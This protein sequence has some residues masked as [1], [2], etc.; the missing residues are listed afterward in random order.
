MHRLNLTIKKYILNA[1]LGILSGGFAYYILGLI[2]FYP[3]DL[4]LFLVFILFLLWALKPTFGVAATL[5]LFLFPIAYNSVTLLFLFIAFIILIAIIDSSSIGP[6]GFFILAAAVICVIQPKLAFLVLLLPVLAGFMGMRRGMIM[7]AVTACWVQAL[8]CLMGRPDVGLLFTP[9]A[10]KPLITLHMWPL[11]SL[12][13]V[14][15][16]NAYANVVS[17]DSRITSAFFLPYLKNPI[18]LIQLALWALCAGVVAFLISRPIVKKVPPY[19]TAVVAGVLVLG[20]GYLVIPALFGLVAPKFSLF[21]LSVLVSA[22]V[23]A[24]VS[25]GLIRVVPLILPAD[26]KAKKPTAGVKK[27]WSD[28]DGMEEVRVF[29]KEA[30]ASQLGAKPSALKQGGQNSPAAGVLLFG[31]PETGM[32]DLARVMAHES[33]ATFLSINRNDVFPKYYDVFVSYSTKD[34]NVAD[35]VVATLEKNNIRCWYA[36]RD[37]KPGSDWGKAVADAIKASKLFLLIFS[38][39]SDRS[40]RVLDEVN[41]AITNELTVLPFRIENLKPNNALMLHLSTRHWL[42]AYETSWEEYLNKLKNTVVSN[43]L[44]EPEKEESLSSTENWSQEIIPEQEGANDLLVKVFEEA[45]NN[46]PAVLFVD[47]LEAFLPRQTNPTASDS[48]A[49]ELGNTFLEQV[50][51]LAA[52]RGVLVVGATHHPA[53]IDLASFNPGRFERCIYLKPPDQNTRCKLLEQTLWEQPLALD[54]DLPKLAG[55]MERFTRTDIQEVCDEAISQVR[56]INNSR[57][58]PITMMDLVAIVKSKRPTFSGELLKEY[59]QFAGQHCQRPS[60]EP[61]KEEAPSQ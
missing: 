34:K 19:F 3:V 13:D 20:I 7:G 59:E 41:Y 22:V 51:Q 24:A 53:L 5:L 58:K 49:K 30:M 57:S 55:L 27:T 48:T 28:L 14:S 61:G 16:I 15:W 12:L 9:A 38:V 43:L 29:L 40:Q 23:A 8:A 17:L 10:T 2:P 47:E 36:P 11:T 50:D 6:Y 21:I 4:K 1:A 39:N 44:A 45:R 60:K 32:S 25:P 56:Q 52:A 42:D 26:S 31:P 54:V 18:F 46:R 35:A 37:I 33:K